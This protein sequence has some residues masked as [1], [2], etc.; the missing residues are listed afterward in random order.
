[1]SWSLIEDYK[2][3]YQESGGSFH[4]TL[5]GPLVLGFCLL[6]VNIVVVGIARSLFYFQY[7]ALFLLI[8]IN[9]VVVP[10]LAWY[11]LRKAGL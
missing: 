7:P 2:D 10:I 11:P 1:M 3:E 8:L 6:V 4:T 5:I 9:A